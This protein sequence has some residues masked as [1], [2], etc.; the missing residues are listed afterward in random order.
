MVSIGIFDKNVIGE[1]IE[2]PSNS[3]KY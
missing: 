3:K 1:K 2:K